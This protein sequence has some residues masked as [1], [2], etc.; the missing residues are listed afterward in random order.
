MTIKRDEKVI[1]HAMTDNKFEVTNR[2][3]EIIF[4]TDDDFHIY[5]KN[6]NFKKGYIEGRYLG[7]LTDDKLYDG[8]CREVFYHVNEGW[9]QK[10]GTHVRTARLVAVNSNT[11]A[12]II[13]Q[14]K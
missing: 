8:Y 14:S 10:N 3:D 1:I 11:G 13:I 12:T 7:E 5:M 6:V 2:E 4:G 9:K